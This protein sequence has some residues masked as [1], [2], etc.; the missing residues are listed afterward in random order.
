VQGREV[1]G[2]RRRRGTVEDDFLRLQRWET[3]GEI[4]DEKRRRLM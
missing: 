4:V 1:H 2:R 3:E